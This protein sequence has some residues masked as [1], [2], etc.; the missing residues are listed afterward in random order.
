MDID[1]RSQGVV[2]IVKL[3]GRLSLGETVDRLRG[4]F[5]DL[6]SSGNNKL[7]LDIEELATM[8]S[9]GIGLLTRALTSAKQQGGALKLVNPSKFVMQTLKMVGL[10]PLFETFSD[11]QTAA[12]SYQ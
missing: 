1:I 7:V 10:L 6:L 9:S 4:T 8:D 5:D 12:A 3:K 11:V 2:K